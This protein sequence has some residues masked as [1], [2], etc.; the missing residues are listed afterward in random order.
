MVPSFSYHPGV[1]IT[2]LDKYRF[3]SRGPTNE[4]MQYFSE[5]LVRE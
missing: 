5:Q 1:R 2:G 4:N 3:D